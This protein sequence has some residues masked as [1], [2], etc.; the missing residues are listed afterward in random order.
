MNVPIS[1]AGPI[2]LFSSGNEV[3]LAFLRFYSQPLKYTNFYSSSKARI[4]DID[5]L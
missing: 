4:S 2:Y 1:R 5:L 3:N